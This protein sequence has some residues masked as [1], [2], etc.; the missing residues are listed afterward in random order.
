MGLQAIDEHF[1]RFLT[2][3]GKEKKITD[4]YYNADRSNFF[5]TQQYVINSFTAYLP[6][7]LR[8]LG[9]IV[10]EFR[11][12]DGEEMALIRFY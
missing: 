3:K 12:F 11:F 5:H 7:I 4:K 10:R 9:E 6:E 2:I 1:T 8:N